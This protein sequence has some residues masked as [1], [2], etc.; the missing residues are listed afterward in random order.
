V[1]LYGKLEWR[2]KEQGEK[3][4]E[5]RKKD[6]RYIECSFKLLLRLSQTCIVEMECGWKGRKRI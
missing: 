3:G 5:E 2:R 4:K 1:K 6:E